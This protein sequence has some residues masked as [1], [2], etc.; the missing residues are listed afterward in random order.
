M[1][2]PLPDVVGPLFINNP[3]DVFQASVSSGQD[4][5]GQIQLAASPSGPFNQ[6]MYLQPM[7]VNFPPSGAP[8]T[9]DLSR[10]VELP[11]F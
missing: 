9:F 4:F 6:R 7:W 10:L 1:T 3:V 2:L 5:Q 8:V 11:V